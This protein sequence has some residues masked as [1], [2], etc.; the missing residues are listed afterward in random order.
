MQ[1]CPGCDEL[2]GR[3]VDVDHL[4]RQRQHVVRHPFADFDPGD[5]LYLFVEAFDVL[6]VDGADHA[7]SR[8]EDLQHVLP[9][10][11]VFTAFDVGVRQLVDDHDFGMGVD[12]GRD[13]HL[14]E[15]LA[16]VKEFA[17]RNDGQSCYQR[18]GFGTSVRFDVADLYVHA[19]FEQLVCLLQHAVALAHT[20]DH[21]DV[22]FKL[23]PVR[24]F[25]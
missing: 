21:A 20:G 14:F 13:V 9:P 10:F 5:F 1:A 22:D 15:L 19:H 17:S 6:D 18:F 12:D 11:P 4:V 24:S 2:L 25:D 7:D 8:I 16:F 23:S 3:Q